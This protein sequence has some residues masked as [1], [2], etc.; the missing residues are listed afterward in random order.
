MI[1]LKSIL[2]NLGS[3]NGWI[4]THIPAF[5]MLSL[6]AIDSTYWKAL[7]WYS[8]YLAVFF[9]CFVLWINPLKSLFP[10]WV[11]LKRLNHYRREIGVAAFS[12]AL[13]H[14][15]CFLIKRGWNVKETLPFLF[16]HPAIVPA[17]WGGFVV[18]AVLAITSNN[19]SVKKL[20]FVRWKK[21]HSKVYIAEWCVFIHM[22]L[23]KQRI[24][25]LLI[26][27][28]LFLLQIIRRYKRKKRH[29]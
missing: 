4:L 24:Q 28:P 15:V 17:F 21:I 8:G 6:L 10:T 13:T 3:W 19:A 29:T 5:L 23:V 27:V 11:W 22:M 1:S 16:L 20:G 14:F 18:M 25:A 9:L 2:K 12:C 7:T 26:F